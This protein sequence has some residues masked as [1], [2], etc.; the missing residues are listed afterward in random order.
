MNKEINYYL[1]HTSLAK[2]L[3]LKP[4]FSKDTL[5]IVRNIKN[6]FKNFFSY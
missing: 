1:E 3:N 6:F 2:E 4:V 5:K